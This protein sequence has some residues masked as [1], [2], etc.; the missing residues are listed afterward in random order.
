MPSPMWTLP[1]KHI[2]PYTGLNMTLQ[3]VPPSFQTVLHN[4]NSNNINNNNNDDDDDDDDD[5]DVNKH[6]DVGRRHHDARGRRSTAPAG[7]LLQ[8]KELLPPVADQKRPASHRQMTVE[9]LTTAAVGPEPML[10][11]TLAAVVAPGT[12]HPATKLLS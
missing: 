7:Q 5:D 8:L 2:Q 6:H 12:N 9:P 11:H 3:L 1:S 4:S 10:V